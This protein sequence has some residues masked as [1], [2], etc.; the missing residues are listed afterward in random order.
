MVLLMASDGNTVVENPTRYPKILP[1]T[2][3]A[4]IK[5]LYKTIINSVI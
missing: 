2:P 5:K 1:L 4:Y 3:V